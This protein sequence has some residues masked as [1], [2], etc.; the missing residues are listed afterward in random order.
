MVALV[1]V[2]LAAPS[3]AQTQSGKIA[4]VSRRDGNLEIY[5][6]NDNGTG[7]TNLTNHHAADWDPAISPDGSMIAFSSNRS[8]RYEIYRMN[9]DGSGVTQLTFGV[10]HDPGESTAGIDWHPDGT[11]ILFSVREAREHRVYQMDSDGSNIVQL[12]D[13]SLWSLYPRYSL[14][15][16]KIYMQR[17]NRF[18]SFS[19][20]VWVANSDGSDL[21]QL[22]STSGGNRIP[23][24]IIVGGVPK[25]LFEKRYLLQVFMMDTDGS[26]ERNLSNNSLHESFMVS[27]RGIADEYVYQSGTRWSY[28]FNIFRRRVDGA[29]P[30]QLTTEGGTNPSWWVPTNRAPVADAGPD[31]VVEAT[32]AAGALVSLNGLLSEDPDDDPL[33]FTWTLDADVIGREGLVVVDLPIGEHLVTLTVMDS[34][35][36]TASDRVL[37]TVRD[38]TAPNITSVTTNPDVLWPPNHRLED[39]TVSVTASDAVTPIPACRI[40][41][42]TSNEP[43]DGL[44]DGDTPVDIVITGGLTLKL[45]AERAGR[46]DGRVYTIEVVCADKA[47]NRT[48]GTTAVVVPT[49]RG[50]GRQ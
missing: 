50:G 14:D 40:A 4:F 18:D 5:I 10:E 25:I 11:K 1:T 34:G 39:I 8:G 42:V 28:R 29:D 12:T 49:S 37:V 20:Q 33:T 15:G 23:A 22:T 19:S 16:T 27:A 46:G 41:S 9:I 7:E 31:Q 6:M 30:V 2:I 35:G 32:S 26:N 44:G 45:R 21:S 47:G 38:T 17:S 36:K 13:I 3:T 48:R 24:E 43:E